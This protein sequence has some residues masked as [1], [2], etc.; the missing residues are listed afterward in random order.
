MLS[1]TTTYK[2]KASKSSRDLND[3]LDSK[4]DG[5]LSE[6]E[7]ENNT[8]S[9]SKL[10]NDNETNYRSQPGT[11]APRDT[12]FNKARNK[13]YEYRSSR[14]VPTERRGNS[15]R[16]RGGYTFRKYETDSPEI[17]NYFP[18]RKF[19]EPLNKHLSA[20]SN[21]KSLYHSKY[22]DSEKPKCDYGLNFLEDT[23]ISKL[24][25][26]LTQETDQEKSIGLCKKLL[27]ALLVPD[28]ARYVRRAFSMLV[29]ALYE[30]LMF[31]SGQ[32]TKQE[33]ARVLGR[34]GYVMETDIR[35]FFDW[36]FHHKYPTS[37]EDIKVLLISSLKETL[38]LEKQ[39][40]KLQEFATELMLQLQTILE[41]TDIP[42]IF[43]ETM[44][45]VLLLEDIYPDILNV[46]FRDTV[47]ILLGW[48]VDNNQTVIVTEFASKSLVKLSKYWQTN[49]SFSLNLMNQFLEDMEPYS[50]QL[51][52][53]TGI[54]DGSVSTDEILERITSLIRAFNTVVKCLG[55][56]FHPINS[57]DITINFI[58]DCL[59]KV[60]KTTTEALESYVPDNLAIS[61]NECIFLLLHILQ[62]KA[63]TVNDQLYN[64][65]DLELSLIQDFSDATLVSMLLMISKTIKELSTNLPIEL[66]SKIVGP[67]SEL[68]KLRFSQS[69]NVQNAVVE[70]Y[71]SLLNLKNIP[72]LQEAYRCVLG[73]L[74]Q[75][76]KLLVPNIAPFCQNNPFPEQNCSC[77][78]A[79]L[80]CLF[81]LRC[82]SLLANATSS[83]IGMWALRPSILELLALKLE[84]YNAALGMKMPSLQYCIF[85]LL[86]SHS[87]C[88]TH[89]VSSSNL[90]TSPDT[91]ANVIDKLG[92]P[93]TLNIDDVSTT[94]PSSGNLTIILKIL[95]KS[96]RT[97]MNLET[98]LLILNWLQEILTYS[99][100]YLNTL[101]R[102]TQFKEISQALIDSGYSCEIPVALAVYS[103]LKILLSYPRVSWNLSFLF[104]VNNLCILH[105][106]STNE[107]IREAYANL[108]A[109]LPWYITIHNCCK[110]PTV[111]RL[112]HSGDISNYNNDTVEIAQHFHMK[113][114]QLGE[115]LQLQFKK[116][117]SYLLKGINH[118]ENWLKDT[119]NC[120]SPLEVPDI[121]FDI[122][123]FRSLALNSRTLLHF[124]LTW[125][126]ALL[127]VNNKLRTPLGKPMDTFMSIE[128][129]LKQ[130]A[131]NAIGITNDNESSSQLPY[132]QEKTRVCLLLEFME[133]LEK[134][135]YNASDGCAEALIAP[136][137]PVRTFFHTNASTCREWMT[138]I[139]LPVVTIA[140]HAGHSTTAIRNAQAKLHDLVN[141]E[142]TQDI[143]FERTVI[144][145]AKAL[146]NL[147]EYEGLQG[148]Y[149]WSNKISNRNM[150]WLKAVS[151]QA[152]RKYETAINEYLKIFKDHVPKT[153]EAEEEGGSSTSSTD[154]NENMYLMKF[155]SNQVTNC[156]KNLNCWKDIIEWQQIESNY[157]PERSNDLV[158][159]EFA[160]IAHA[161]EEGDD[162]SVLEE[163]CVWKNV[164]SQTKCA[165]WGTETLLKETEL[166]NFKIALQLKQTD[167]NDA[168][169]KLNDNLKM[170]QCNVQ[171]CLRS[172]PSEYIQDFLLLQHITVGLINVIESQPGCVFDVVSDIKKLKDVNT[173]ILS[174]VLLWSEY[175]KNIDDIVTPSAL[176]NI[177]INTIKRARKEGNI[178]F[179]LNQINKYLT[180]QKDYF[181]INEVNG[182]PHSLLDNVAQF[183]IQ[184]NNKLDKNI[185]SLENAKAVREI[186]KA[187]YGTDG[188]KNVALNVCAAASAGISQQVNL[189]GNAELKE[190][191]SK[192]IITLS[193][194]I[195]RENDQ[196]LVK[197]VSSPLGRLIMVIP[198][199]GLCDNREANV[200]PTLDMAA[201]KLLQFGVRQYPKS[202][203]IWSAF[204]EWCYLWGKNALNNGIQLTDNDRL[205]IQANV[206]PGITSE[207]LQQIYDILSQSKIIPDKDDII[208]NDMN[209]SERIENQLETVQI[210]SNGYPE[211]K[212]NLVQ[213]WTQ[214]QKRIYH[215]YELSAEAF[216]QA[217]QLC[218]DCETIQKGTECLTITATLRLLRFIVKHAMELQTVLNQGLS[219][220]PTHPWKA[221]IPQLFSRLNHPQEYVRLRVSELL[222]R[223]AEVA[224]H[225]I[226][227]PA[228]VGAVEGGHKFDLSDITMPKDYLTH[229]EHT[230]LGDIEDE[231]DDNSENE[232]SRDVLHSCFMSMV[233][234]LSKQAPETIT[235]VQSF[236]NELRRI[237]LLWDELWV[238][239]LV[240]HHAEITKRLSQLEAEIT[241]TENNMS[242]T[243]DEKDQLIAEKHRIIIKPIVFILEQ[244]HAITSR[245]PETPHEVAFQERYLELINDVLDKLKNP[246]N[247]H[248]PQE[249]WQPLKTLQVKLQQRAHK[250]VSFALKMTEISPILASMRDTVIA[251]PGLARNAI[252]KVTILSISLQVNVLPTKTKP[253]KLFFHGS[254][255]H[256]YTYL[257]KGME[258]LHLDER[259]MQFLTISNTM[260]AKSSEKTNHNVYRARHYSVIPLGLRSGLIRWVDGTTPMFSLYKRWQL[261]E[262]AMTNM[263]Q[264]TNTAVVL[265]PSE[266]FYNKLNPL[267]K[268]HAVK[269][270][271][272]RKEWPLVALKQV[273]TELMAETPNDLLARELWCRSVNAGAWWQVTKNYSYSVA[274][275][276]M[277]G[278]IIGL[279]DRHLDN[280]LIDLTSGEVIH[281]DYNV[282]FEKGKQLRV[283]EKVP[284]RMTPNMEAAL[285]ITGVE[286]SVFLKK[287]LI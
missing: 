129:A 163:L 182:N 59:C 156:Y 65:I 186:V 176:L 74:E 140:L 241:K 22:Y 132:I 54:D 4:N 152:N 244:L 94:S 178:N 115:L 271:E 121:N 111:Y 75:A 109:L 43:M 168:L 60:L 12:R 130:L 279:G 195:Q 219:T 90:V 276:S 235:Q 80:T 113:R 99:K 243:N 39:N 68:L 42:D 61:A 104:S 162:M 139:R 15:W 172:L 92:L 137:K 69:E 124:W 53:R 63:S 275:M 82:L 85:Y 189:S 37:S 14:G 100:I 49:V 28:N 45:V 269:N 145:L 237:S 50:E 217:L 177:R 264:S 97:E 252:K 7:Q 23:R 83:I 205:Y 206:P 173:S 125:E 198:D 103:N 211:H 208:N 258:D 98:L 272:N 224:P 26:R 144:S 188:K 196:Q 136:S 114:S 35:R 17:G 229:T 185:W 281:I 9:I 199:I 151:D 278:Y 146:L 233:D 86:Y 133:H 242:L 118:E 238:S 117:T 134:V 169:N 170:I 232:E 153:I 73:D 249:S 164:D 141:A 58:I 95:T 36:Q 267:L 72:L 41:T 284:F 112:K 183:L 31:G 223:I 10:H 1:N 210:L 142:K 257:F 159:Y 180:I 135:I 40:S 263:K 2:L 81:L 253:K 30:V 261:R 256:T 193:K 108:L 220:T 171:E 155:M 96:L 110:I 239:T 149:E 287:K 18:S 213:V 245:E 204:G 203:K 84:P 161:F 282:C 102:T 47:D 70:V 260:M 212:R 131:K 266:L 225:L 247:P 32:S 227:F 24:I 234:T 221:I 214:A 143:E 184:S 228:V 116:I 55:D 87:R 222:C 6:E 16:G 78:E 5:N 46:H 33:A 89:F 285:G 127:C 283:P 79:E 11:F 255:G 20:D 280:V 277:I 56:K 174:K 52:N 273:L 71:H 226:I 62:S 160:K 123:D 181:G 251:M 209:M 34:V 187:L 13:S 157:I 67:T 236:V 27:D 154:N 191:G 274:V 259:I 76:Y 286:V 21:S 215:Y 200:I 166:N 148:L 202:T 51:Y 106:N 29:E 19:Q 201:G 150:T 119:F 197:E 88:Y 207:E 138:R 64:L 165:K 194:W 122:A 268:E 192:L 8:R 250:R 105:V 44:D 25:R 270:T 158:D 38:T 262:A 120:C 265:R 107:C 230:E 101:C 231:Y 218:T 248:K 240:Q 190:H 254:D 126:S 77:L 57:P 48:H 3:Y 179:A 93:G 128:T 167:N 246:E 66:V 175:F 147:N 91:K 216:F